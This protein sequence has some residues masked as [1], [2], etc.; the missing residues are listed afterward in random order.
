MDLE[1]ELGMTWAEIARTTYEV[2]AAVADDRNQ[3][4]PTWDEL[5]MEDRIAREC[6]MRSLESLLNNLPH[7]AEYW[8]KFAAKR[9]SRQR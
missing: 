2:Q 9:L 8:K 4:I 1:V 7:N 6:G 5:S 3:E